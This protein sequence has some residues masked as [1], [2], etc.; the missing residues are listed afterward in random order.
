MPTLPIDATVQV[1]SLLPYGPNKKEIRINLW[2]ISDYRMTTEMEMEDTGEKPLKC[3]I[4]FEG[5]SQKGLM[6]T[7]MLTH[8]GEKP[9]KCE[10]CSKG[11][12]RSGNLN[13]IKNFNWF[14]PYC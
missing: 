10:I 5:F 2:Q 3:V 8:T 11:F 13:W 1:P 9:F 7:H 4:C 14:Y 6:K 12:N